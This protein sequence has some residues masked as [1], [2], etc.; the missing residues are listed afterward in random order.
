MAYLLPKFP[1]NDLS[2]STQPQNGVM[3]MIVRN[4]ATQLLTL[5]SADRFQNSSTGNTQVNI[6]GSNGQYNRSTNNNLINNQPWNSFVL[7]RS[8]NLMEAFATRIAVTEVRF[9]W[10]IPNI[11]SANNSIW[12]RM[13]ADLPGNPLTL[14]TLTIPTGFYDLDG[15][16]T[17]LNTAISNLS[18][19]P[20]NPPSVSVSSGGQF[21]WTPGVGSG[22]L[23]SLYWFNPYT[24]LSAPPESQ[25][26]TSSSL[27]MTMGLIYEQASGGSNLTQPLVG[28]PTLGLY[29]EYVDI[30][31]EKLNYYSHTKD[32]SSS[33]S[34]NKGLVCRLYL[35]DEIS[36]PQQDPPGQ[37][38]LV[39]H[40]QFKTPKNV[41]WNKEAVIDLLDISVLDQYG[42]LVPLPTL[43]P[44]QSQSLRQTIGSYPDFQITLLAS[45]N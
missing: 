32:G 25:F 14:Y 12:I 9:P 19:A 33:S 29:T 24:D 13:E 16:A 34:T 20:L 28:N 26:V 3:T 4:P 45:E 31:S 8:Q 15:I 37:K 17:A 42:Q 40:R 35:A 21:I 2:Y 22:S 43:L 41:M 44:V 6:V 10:F 11:N 36:I 7:Q 1:T 30:V 23:F 18:P 27:A 5:N 38:P 39:I